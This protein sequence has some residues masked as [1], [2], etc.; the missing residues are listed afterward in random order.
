MSI[1]PA[2]FNQ[3]EAVLGFTLPDKAGP[4]A[5]V[6]RNHRCI[7]L[8]VCLIASAIMLVGLWLHIKQFE[9]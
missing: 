1:I 7:G 3:I 5:M 9:G 8:G 2:T 6:E 4:D